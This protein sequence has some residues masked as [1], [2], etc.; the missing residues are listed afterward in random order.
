MGHLRKI[1]TLSLI[2]L[3]AC[4]LAGAALGDPSGPVKGEGFGFVVA[5]DAGSG[6]LRLDD[7]IV[8]RVS[9][10]TRMSRAD[11]SRVTLETLS[12]SE[13]AE[14]AVRFEGVL[15]VLGRE[16]TQVDRLPLPSSS[17]EGRPDD[18]GAVRQGEQG[19]TAREQGAGEEHAQDLRG[20]DRRDARSPAEQ[21]A[22]EAT[23]AGVLLVVRHPASGATLTSEPARPRRYQGRQS[24]RSVPIAVRGGV[25]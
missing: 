23:R 25:P 8:L 14:V 24:G 20:E 5:V 12:V 18:L 9:G 15:E 11:G 2:L 13:D 6:E 7:G 1:A 3:L 17:A 10:K 19:E 16:V 4:S 21:V 22:E